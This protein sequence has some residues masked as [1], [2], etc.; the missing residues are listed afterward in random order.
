MPTPE[1]VRKTQESKN[2]PKEQETR[3]ENEVDET[4]DETHIV[5]HQQYIDPNTG[6][7]SVKTHGPMPVKD[8]P[9]YEKK[10][11]L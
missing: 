11:G 6:K 3:D 1:D 5:S 8:W 4:E 10:N 2:A 9:A 7:A